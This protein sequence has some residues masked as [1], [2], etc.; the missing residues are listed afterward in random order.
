MVSHPPLRRT[1][2]RGTAIRRSTTL[3]VGLFSNRSDGEYSRRMRVG[4]STSNR[5]GPA[6]T[7]ADGRAVP[8]PKSTGVARSTGDRSVVARAPAAPAAPAVWPDPPGAWPGRA[9]PRRRVR[10]GGRR[11]AC[12]P[13][14]SCA[15][16]RR[17]TQKVVSFAGAELVDDSRH[18]VRHPP[19][20]HPW[21]T[22]ARRIAARA[23]DASNEHRAEGGPTVRR[24]GGSQKPL[25]STTLVEVARPPR[26]HRVGVGV[27]ESRRI[28]SRPRCEPGSSAPRW[29]ASTR[30]RHRRSRGR[31]D[32][33]CTRQTP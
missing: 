22:S 21:S 11:Y 10:P 14:H 8:A 18:A 7:I 3:T 20:R 13:S 12:W 32:Y 16:E 4:A 17:N 25:V 31:R 27:G 5:A 9:R 33:V 1:T 28:R 19:S 29:P 23:P 30:K 26:R 2:Y 15:T 24:V 6:S